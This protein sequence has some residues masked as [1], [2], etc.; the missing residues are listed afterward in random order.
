MLFSIQNPALTL[1]MFL[2]PF[3]FELGE[4][5]GDSYFFDHLKCLSAFP[6]FFWSLLR[7][8]FSF[9]RGFFPQTW[10]QQQQQQERE[11]EQEDEERKEE[12]R[13]R[14]RKRRRIRKR[15][16]KK[17]QILR[18]CHF[19]D[20]PYPFHP[21]DISPECRFGAILLARKWSGQKVRPSILHRRCWGFS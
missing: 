17:K 2:Q 11:Q 16:R 20:H 13:R 5:E 3:L 10:R 14:K 1:S 12:E 4:R 19:P 15:R 9:G 7:I 8:F 18:F 6:S 21:K